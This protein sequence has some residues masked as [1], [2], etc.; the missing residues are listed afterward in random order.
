MTG[1]AFAQEVYVID[2]GNSRLYKAD[3][4]TAGQS[5][6]LLSTLPTPHGIAVDPDNGDIY[7]T[8]GSTNPTNGR[9]IRSI[10][11]VLT[12]P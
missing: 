2:S 7:Y 6:I 10:R 8:D 1:T 9:I 5:D 4:N 3:K 11:M 12:R